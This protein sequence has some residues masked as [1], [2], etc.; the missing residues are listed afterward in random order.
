M[1]YFHLQIS[2]KE[3]IIRIAEYIYIYETGI[4]QEEITL[5]A[6]S[7]LESIFSETFEKYVILHI[8]FSQFISLINLSNEYIIV[9]CIV[10]WVMH[11]IKD[12]LQL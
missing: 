9:K 10:I 6:K 7:I 4:S 5:K 8:P 1:L 12:R 2:T 11:H 3:H